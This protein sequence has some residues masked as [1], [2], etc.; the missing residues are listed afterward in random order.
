M[1]TLQHSV[2]P[3]LRFDRRDFLKASGAAALGLAGS[4][5]LGRSAF[6]QNIGGT[7]DYLGWQGEEMPGA[8][9]AFA[10]EHGIKIN[11]SYI[12]SIDDV[13]ARY[14]GGGGSGFDLLSTTTSTSDQLEKNGHVL[15][16]LDLER[17]PRHGNLANYFTQN[18]RT[19]GIAD[20]EGKLFAIPHSFGVFGI[21]YDSKAISEPKAWTDLLDPKFKGRIT[22]PGDPGANF[23]LAAHILGH[24]PFRTPKG[25]IDEIAAFMK[26]FID[27][28]KT[29]APS[30][31]D[32][33]S[34]IGSGEVVASFLGWAA[35][36]VF[37]AAAGN[38]NVRT[39]ITPTDGTFT[40]VEA[41][42]IP[43]GADKADTA[44]AWINEVLDPKVNAA[45]AMEL[46]A[47]PTVKGAAAFIDRA[48]SLY[49]VDDVD[50]FLAK[51]PVLLQAP[52]ESDEFITLGEWVAKFQELLVK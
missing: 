51:R 25:K 27:Q 36:D 5:M 4:A 49:P 43:Q 28:S 30:Y 19:I 52:I 48:K 22:M 9:G 38:N 17:I 29:I 1:K 15:T 20:A 37:A 14:A 11:P 47:G 8:M 39:N 6:A 7:L 45:A 12:A 26:Q 33:A 44:Y 18:A 40:F 24:D 21:T 3:G 42:V 31:G 35:I 23:T 13:D 41:Y 16:P 10:K 50:A 34:L 32:V 46:A 2:Q